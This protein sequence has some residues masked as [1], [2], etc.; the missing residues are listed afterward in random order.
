[1]YANLRLEVMGTGK[2]GVH[3]SLTR[4]ILSCAHYFQAPAT[5]A[6]LNCHA[7]RT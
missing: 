3:V 6:N 7:Q 2:N 5:Q 4:P 1:M